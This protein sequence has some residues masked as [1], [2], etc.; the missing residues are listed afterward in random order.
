MKTKTIAIFL[1]VLLAA[2][3]WPQTA[4]AQDGPNGGDKLV[5]GGTFTLSSGET[6]DSNLFVLGGSVRLEADSRV[7][8]DVVTVGGN[9]EVDGEVNGD[10][11]SIGAR[12]ELGENA[13][14]RGDVTTAGANFRRAPG[15]QITGDVTSDVPNPL[16]LTL[17]GGIQVPNVQV[18]F[19]P[20]VDIFWFFFKSFLWGV[21][22]VLAVMF[23]PRNIERITQAAATQPLISGGI[24]MLTVVVGL[25]VLAVMAITILLIPVSLLG[26]FVL[27][28][29]WALGIISVGTE[30][31]KRLTLF[32]RQ[33][34]PLAVSAWLGTFLLTL[35]TNGTAELIPCVGWTFPAL[36]G[37]LGVGAVLLTRFGTQ[38]YPPLGPSVYSTLPSSGVPSSPERYTPPASGGARVYPP[39]RDE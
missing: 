2:L 3:S 17:P 6:L 8:G 14:V 5:L 19:S 37:F 26:I 9:I 32:A 15:A 30:I 22:A 33:E 4:L 10:V 29:A 39:D 11:V 7:N 20:L 38:T 21:L 36:I 12:L 31:G 16:E 23:F 34:W 35:L 27:V 24:G 18:R 13:V 28:V 1:L 25:L